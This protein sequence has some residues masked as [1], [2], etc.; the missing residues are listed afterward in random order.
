MFIGTT[1]NKIKMVKSRLMQYDCHFILSSIRK[2]LSSNLIV[3]F[4]HVYYVGIIC[5]YIY[6]RRIYYCYGK[7][8][9][10]QI[11]KFINI[12][13]KIRRLSINLKIIIVWTVLHVF[14]NILVQ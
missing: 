4:S 2:I 8:W 10:N 5:I 13:R 3:L 11:V 1:G 7:L 6:I 9:N 14:V 12:V